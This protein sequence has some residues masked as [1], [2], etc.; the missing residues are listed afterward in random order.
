ML[1][2]FSKYSIFIIMWCKFYSKKYIYIMFVI[3]CLFWTIRLQIIRLQIIGFGMNVFQMW[4]KEGSEPNWCRFCI[5]HQLGS[6]C[7]ERLQTQL[8][9]DTEPTTTGSRTLLHIRNPFIPN[10]IIC[11]LMIY[12]LIVQN[13]YNSIT[14]ITYN[15]V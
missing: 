11:N 4:R 9:Y 15:E 2:I 8:V 5:I 10:P 7:E 6:E 12:N 1:T 14:N 3:L 13:K